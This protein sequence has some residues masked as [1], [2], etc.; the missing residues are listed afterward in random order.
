MQLEYFD[1]YCIHTPSNGKIIETYRALMEL[2]DKGLIKYVYVYKCNYICSLI[3]TR[4]N[5]TDIGTSKHLIY[6]SGCKMS[7]HTPVETLC[8]VVFKVVP[9]TIGR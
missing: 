5:Y 8:Q 6:Y 3:L 9:N 7:E 4:V 1:M 2:K